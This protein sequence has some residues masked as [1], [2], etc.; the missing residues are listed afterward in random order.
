MAELALLPFALLAAAGP[1]AGPYG[2]LR[3][4]SGPA[5]LQSRCRGGSCQGNPGQ[6]LLPSCRPRVAEFASFFSFQAERTAA[7]R[8][9]GARSIASLVPPRVTSAPARV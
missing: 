7:A 1:A 6:L 9:A 5:P 2:N 4:D 8:R 3:A